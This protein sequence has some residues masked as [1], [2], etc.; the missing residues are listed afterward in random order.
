MLYNLCVQQII[1]NMLS[2]TNTNKAVFWER[3]CIS[4]SALLLVS[5][6]VFSLVRATSTFTNTQKQVAAYAFTPEPETVTH[7]V[8]DTTVQTVENSSFYATKNSTYLTKGQVITPLTGIFYFNPETINNLQLSLDSWTIPSQKSSFVLDTTTNKLFALTGEIQYDIFTSPFRSFLDITTQP[9][10][11]R[12]L[13]REYVKSDE[14][15]NLFSIIKST[16]TLHPFWTDFS[17]PKV[18]LV[19]ELPTTTRSNEIAISFLSDRSGEFV[20]N[21]TNQVIVKDTLLE[22]TS[23]PLTPGNNQF[24]YYVQDSFGNTSLKESKTITQD[25]C[26]EVK[27]C[28]MCGNP[29][30]F[31]A[32]VEPESLIITGNQANSPTPIPSPVPNPPPPVVLTTT[33]PNS[34]SSCD[35]SSFQSEFLTLINNYRAQNGVGSLY[36][37]GALSVAACDHAIW[38][39]NTGIFSHQ[40]VN[41]S[42]PP[43]RCANRG[44]ACYAENLAF[45]DPD[46][47]PLQMFNLFKNSPPHNAT[48]LN[49]SYSAIGVALSSIYSATV[50]R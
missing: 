43:E 12:M 17:T 9:I 27:E 21:D 10:T 50:F 20:L 34:T 42:Y 18:T 39:T 4:I 28:G 32:P 3:L 23:L 35:S 46:N 37:D 36:L 6:G 26:F 24:S 14:L 13:E 25:S 30:C 2:K 48:M 7:I 15:Q 19:T 22:I 47:S 8:T 29:V 31:I 38:M 33:Q 45:S 49:G 5:L 1:N 44:T 16:T 11:T 40:G 41:R